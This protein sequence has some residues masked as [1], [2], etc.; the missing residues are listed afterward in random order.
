MDY[1]YGFDDET[2]DV[3]ILYEDGTI[4]YFDEAEGIIIDFVKA[5]I[6]LFK[7]ILEWLTSE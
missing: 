5:I 4:I 1:D 3:F 7:K 2:N 6:Y